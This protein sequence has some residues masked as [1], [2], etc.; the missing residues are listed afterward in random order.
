MQLLEGVVA[1]DGDCEHLY[2]RIYCKDDGLLG[3]STGCDSIAC[4]SCEQESDLNTA[5]FG[6]EEGSPD[7]RYECT[8]STLTM[9]WCDTDEI[10]EEL[11]AGNVTDN[12]FCL[13][14][15]KDSC[16]RR[17]EENECNDHL[18][19]FCDVD[20]TVMLGFECTTCDAAPGDSCVAA[21]SLVNWGLDA[22]L[23]CADNPDFEMSCH[24]MSLFYQPCGE[25]AAQ[26]PIGEPGL[27]LC[28]GNDDEVDEGSYAWIGYVHVD[29]AWQAVDGQDPSW[30]NWVDGQEPEAGCAALNLEDGTWRAFDCEAELPSLCFVGAAYNISYE[31]LEDAYVPGDLC[32]LSTDCLCDCYGDCSR[33]SDGTCGRSCSIATIE[34][35]F[36]NCDACGELSYET[37]DTCLPFAAFHGGQPE[38]DSFLVSTLKG[39]LCAPRSTNRRAA[40]STS[41]RIALTRTARRI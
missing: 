5:V 4:D 40:R 20:D 35:A 30:T 23:S 39:T 6:C 14:D 34:S 9:R 21:Q 32:S 27:C 12:Q 17:L 26:I 15:P 24:N 31:H 38:A 13:D 22:F 19:W 37:G 3:Y 2:Q 16:E 11:G 33:L 1:P 28:N 18:W 29:D 8:G 41:A 36:A 25:G 7:V 10:I